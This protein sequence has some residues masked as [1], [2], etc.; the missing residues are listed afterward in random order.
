MTRRHPPGRDVLHPMTEEDVSG[1]VQLAGQGRMEIDAEPPVR[2]IVQKRH[3]V[4]QLVDLTPRTRAT[5]LLPPLD[6]HH[7]AVSIGRLIPGQ[8]EIAGR[9]DHRDH[10]DRPDSQGGQP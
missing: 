4:E 5:K 2:P 6:R 9:G 3:G 1:Q 8:A 7:L 10:R